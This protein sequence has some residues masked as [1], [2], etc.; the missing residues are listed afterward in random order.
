MSTVIQSNKKSRN[1][2]IFGKINWSL[3]IYILLAIFDNIAY[4]APDPN[5]D[6]TNPNTY[7]DYY[8]NSIESPF[9]AGYSIGIY[10]PE[11]PTRDLGWRL[12]IKR[13][14]CIDYRN[15]CTTGVIDEGRY[16]FFILYNIY[17]GTLRHFIYIQDTNYS[18]DKQH[19]I[20]TT[21]P[22]TDHGMF[23]HEGEYA[24]SLEEKHEDFNQGFF[25]ESSTSVLPAYTKKWAVFDRT[26]SYDPSPIDPYIVYK[27]YFDAYAKSDVQLSGEFAFKLSNNP[28]LAIYKGDVMSYEQN[29]TNDSEVNIVDALLQTNATVKKYKADITKAEEDLDQMAFDYAEEY[30][31][32]ADPSAIRKQEL[33]ASVAEIVGSGGTNAL[34]YAAA[35]YNVYKTL[36]T[37]NADPVVTMQYG[38]GEMNLAGSI[39]N[40]YPKNFVAFSL[41]NSTPG[42]DTARSML[43]L[44]NNLG[45]WSLKHQPSAVVGRDFF[46][47]ETSI[48]DNIIINPESDMLL[49]DV[50]VSLSIQDIYRRPANSPNQWGHSGKIPTSIKTHINRQYNTLYEYNYYGWK[51]YR[52]NL[53]WNNYPTEV[54]PNFNGNL[55]QMYIYLLSPNGMYSPEVDPYYAKYA[56]FLWN[57]LRWAELQYNACIDHASTTYGDFSSDLRCQDVS[58]NNSVLVNS[59]EYSQ[60]PNRLNSVWRLYG[61]DTDSTGTYD[62]D[63]LYR[64]NSSNYQQW[65]VFE[66]FKDEFK[67]VTV[68]NIETKVLISLVHKDGKSGPTIWNPDTGRYEVCFTASGP[69]RVFNS[70]RSCYEPVRTKELRTYKTNIRRINAARNSRNIDILKYLA[71]PDSENSSVS[72]YYCEPRG[73]ST[74]NEYI[75]WVKIGNYWV[76]TYNNGGRY[77]FGIGA[78]PWY[79]TAGTSTSIQ[80]TPGYNTTAAIPENWRVWI[81][82]NQDFQFS[83]DEL[84]YEGSG[85]GSM[86]GNISIPDSAQPG[87]TR[88]RIAMSNAPFPTNQCA[89]IS[90][91]EIEDY[92][93]TINK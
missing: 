68:D 21:I 56:R 35:A 5:W 36:K 60:N 48:R 87:R 89:S 12:Y 42:G 59:V 40:E 22:N 61:K 54:Y 58:R 77:N 66:P 44:N 50:Q 47:I 16:P 76:A 7:F 11:K 91:G 3:Q 84:V 63:Y 1:Y 83:T 23:L 90:R 69:G 37:T 14:E 34:A 19:I 65:F 43:N 31:N 70:K 79:L 85:S 20:K 26:I 18:G 75:Y 15:D 71:S 57:E 51:G 9:D 46:D 8:H 81:D 30:Q 73:M 62:T 67:N 27:V 4:S 17:T 41:H 82:F 25:G 29:L 52:N 72:P 33:F 24:Y 38:A 86:Y 92:L 45:V 39:V 28:K 64:T 49:E 88:M 74:N 13:L 6:W 2:Y 93:V 32:S 55:F 80:L 78:Y 53:K 10:T